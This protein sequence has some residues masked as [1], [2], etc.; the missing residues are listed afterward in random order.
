MNKISPVSKT[1]NLPVKNA[2]L[3]ATSGKPKTSITN[4]QAKIEMPK[5]FREFL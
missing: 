5:I 4:A 1:P 2:K 3:T